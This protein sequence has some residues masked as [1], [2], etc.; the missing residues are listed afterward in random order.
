MHTNHYNLFPTSLISGL[1]QMKIQHFPLGSPLK[2]AYSLESVH[3]FPS[4]IAVDF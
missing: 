3:V 1:S 2:S 4:K